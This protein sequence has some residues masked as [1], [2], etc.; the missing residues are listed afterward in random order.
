MKRL[1]VGIAALP[2]LAGVAS[3]AQPM[4]LSDAQMDKVTAGD[5][6]ADFVVV[7]NAGSLAFGNFAADSATY[8][9]TLADKGPDA[10][11]AE[12][13]AKANAASALTASFVVVGSNAA[14]VVSGLNSAQ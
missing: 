10:G 7:G 8:T 13:A 2:F 4:P 1:L 14:A 12:A 11:V 9:N 5:D 3:A 6:G